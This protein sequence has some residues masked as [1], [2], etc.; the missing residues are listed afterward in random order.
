MGFPYPFPLLFGPTP[1]PTPIIAPATQPPVRKSYQQWA[2]AMAPGWLQTS[3]ATTWLGAH[4]YIKDWLIARLK[5][6]IMQRFPAFAMPDALAQI[7]IERG[8]VQSPAE[9][10]GAYAQRLINAWATWQGAGTAETLLQLLA[11]FGYT[12]AVIVQQNQWAFSL[13]NGALVTTALPAYNSGT[14]SDPARL[15]QPQWLFSLGQPAVEAGQAQPLPIVTSDP[16]DQVGQP[17]NRRWARYAVIFPTLPIGPA[18]LPNW[19]DV[20]ATLSTSTSPSLAEVNIIRSLIAQW[21]PGISG[22]QGIY[23]V[24]AGQ[25][26]GW[27][28]LTWVSTDTWAS[29]WNANVVRWSPTVGSAT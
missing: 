8:L 2:V 7:G 21:G 29:L 1:T 17:E 12:E 9:S 4:G 11:V 16:P 13:S 10:L 28:S 23:A 26:F 18:P 15:C 5:Q 22:C 14:M 19:T 27:P 3:Q 20:Q 6:G 24:T 25:I